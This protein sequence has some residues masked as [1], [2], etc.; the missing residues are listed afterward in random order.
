MDISYDSAK[1]EDIE[2]IFQLNVHLIR[3]YENIIRC[4]I[5]FIIK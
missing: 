2:C 5:G 3:E 4:W 1:P